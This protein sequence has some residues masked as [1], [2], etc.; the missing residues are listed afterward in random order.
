MHL[1]E[2]TEIAKIYDALRDPVSRRIYKHRLL[3]S[4]TG[5]TAEITDLVYE[6]SCASEV[7]RQYRG[8]SCHYCTWKSGDSAER[9]G[10]AEQE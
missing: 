7:L 10:A 6:D 5:D 3:Y 4:L 9:H 1:P 8:K 2:I